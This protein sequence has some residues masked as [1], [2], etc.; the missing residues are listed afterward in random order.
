MIDVKTRSSC[1]DEIDPRRRRR[2]SSVGNRSH[3]V[4]IVNMT[5]DVIGVLNSYGAIVGTSIP[6]DLSRGGATIG[7]TGAGAVSDFDGGEDGSDFDG[8]CYGGFDGDGAG[9]GFLQWR[10]DRR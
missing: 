5:S 10:D 7:G 6:V 1:S 3:G 4:V 8:G 9:S 2:S